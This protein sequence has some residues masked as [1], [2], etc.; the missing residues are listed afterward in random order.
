MP[1]ELLWTTSIKS[2]LDIDVPTNLWALVSVMSPDIEY[3]DADDT[4]SINNRNK[5]Y[6]RFMK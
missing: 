2:L 6:A 1:T 5:M 3:A 4:E